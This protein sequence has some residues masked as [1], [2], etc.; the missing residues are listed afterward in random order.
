MFLGV[1]PPMTH[2]FCGGCNRLRLTADGLLKTCLLSS[3]DINLKDRLRGGTD[4]DE[5]CALVV[6]ALSE[7]GTGIIWIM[8]NADGGCSS[9]NNSRTMSKIGG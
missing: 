6:K 5:L 9:L 3:H 7:K 1:I 8:S 2:K 4:P